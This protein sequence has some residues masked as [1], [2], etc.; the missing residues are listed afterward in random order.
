MMVVLP[1]CFGSP[2]L[3]GSID[4]P[5]AEGNHGTTR[6]CERGAESKTPDSCEPGVFT[7][8]SALLNRGESVAIQV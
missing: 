1:P 3:S 2:L 5:A 6:G 7:I 4:L 8:I